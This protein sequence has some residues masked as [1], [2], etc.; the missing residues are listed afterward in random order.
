MSAMQGDFLSPQIQ[1]F[2]KMFI[3]SWEKKRPVAAPAAAT[4]PED[5]D[6]ETEVDAKA[7]ERSKVDGVARQSYID[8]ERQASTDQEPK[9]GGHDRFVH[10]SATFLPPSFPLKTFLLTSGLFDFSPRLRL[11]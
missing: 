7:G 11:C 8:M 2:M 9:Q 5:D 6:A 1:S 4:Q 3:K 10:V